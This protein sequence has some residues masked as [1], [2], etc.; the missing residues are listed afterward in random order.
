MNIYTKINSSSASNQIGLGI[1]IYTEI[2]ASNA[3]SI[4]HDYKLTSLV[5]WMHLMQE[6]K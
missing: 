3:S 5:K 4:K 6:M 2:T 1:N